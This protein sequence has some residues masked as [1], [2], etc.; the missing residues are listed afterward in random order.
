MSLR[1]VIRP[2]VDYTGRRYV[3]GTEEQRLQAYRETAE[4]IRRYQEAQTAL[5]SGLPEIV[6]D[7]LRFA[8]FGQVE[9][10]ASGDLYQL[11]RGHVDEN[12]QCC[13]AAAYFVDAE[14]RHRLA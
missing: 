14:R 12:P 9:H 7:E 4:E 8:R 3:E 13:G 11:V 10:T 5:K 1:T 6:L 2:V